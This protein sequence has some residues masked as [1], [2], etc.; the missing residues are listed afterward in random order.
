MSN[1]SEFNSSGEETSPPFTIVTSKRNRL[2]KNNIFSESIPTFNHFLL[3]VDE[4]DV[5]K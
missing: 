5:L 2:K 3:D 4:A 1:V